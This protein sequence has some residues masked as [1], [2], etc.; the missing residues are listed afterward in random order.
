MAVL[1]KICR[2]VLFFQ[3]L[4]NFVVGFWTVVN[5]AGFEETFGFQGAGKHAVQSIGI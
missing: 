4:N 3:A 5:P 2:I 1:K